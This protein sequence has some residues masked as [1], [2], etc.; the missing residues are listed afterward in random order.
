M[1]QSKILGGI[2]NTNLSLS[3]KGLNKKYQTFS[4]KDINIDVPKG[5]IMGFIG[6]N[7]SGK[8]TTIKSILNIIPFHGGEILVNGLD[9]VKNN[10]IVKQTIGYVG[11]QVNLYSEV[12]AFQIYKFVKK[13]YSTWDE[14]YFNK[15]V[16]V[17]KLDLS[18]KIKELSKGTAIKFLLTLA[19]SHHP[20]LLVLDE[21][22]SGLDPVI[23]AEVLEIILD[24]VKKE[25]SSVFFSSHI[26]ED[27][28]KV[29]DYVTYINNGQILL[30]D[31]K[32]N[33]L[34]NYRKLEFAEGIPDRLVNYLTFV[35]DN[36]AIVDDFDQ[37]KLKWHADLDLANV[38][39][40][41]LDDILLFLINDQS[42]NTL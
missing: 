36:I 30:T 25:N 26:T 9:N 22:T 37:F 14:A 6:P 42:S 28:V 35:R 4:L 24:H 27:I 13:Y 39:N 33:V 3:V 40:A 41:G 31:K 8:S 21:P 32:V 29:A 20:E 10:I 15:L 1:C 2:M 18:K 23:R 34:N 19:L 38:R 5:S 11:E 16:S 7:G 12:P 17:F